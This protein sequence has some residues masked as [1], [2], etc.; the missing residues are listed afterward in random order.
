MGKKDKVKIQVERDIVDKLINLKKFK[1]TYS[2]VI[3][4]LLRKN[5]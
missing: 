2:D 1:E 4:K 3:R 5:E